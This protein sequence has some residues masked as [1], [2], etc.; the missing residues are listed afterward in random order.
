MDTTLPLRERFY[1]AKQQYDLVLDPFI[2][3]H[4]LELALDDR[5]RITALEHQAAE[6]LDAKQAFL[7][8]LCKILAT[9]SGEHAED[10]FKELYLV[11]K[12]DGSPVIAGKTEGSLKTEFLR[13]K[14]HPQ[15]TFQLNNEVQWRD[16]SLFNEN[17]KLIEAADH[18]KTLLIEFLEFDLEKATGFVAF[19]KHHGLSQYAYRVMRYKQKRC[20]ELEQ[21]KGTPPVIK[22]KIY[23]ARLF[24]QAEQAGLYTSFDF[25][26]WKPTGLSSRKEAR[27]R[28]ERELFMMGEAMTREG[29]AL[30]TVKAT[31]TQ[32][33]A[34]VTPRRSTRPRP[35]INRSRNNHFIDRRYIVSVV[36]EVSEED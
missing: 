14:D 32:P 31:P 2:A 22:P 36:G 3:Q 12:Y 5:E 8:Q 4:N 15:H 28:L 29:E 16:P 20:S 13:I 35:A 6:Y 18:V 9:H 7:N 30:E 26:N 17:R 10:T 34:S 27:S 23:E 24:G 25:E 11:F 33:Q 21:L 1:D 19:L